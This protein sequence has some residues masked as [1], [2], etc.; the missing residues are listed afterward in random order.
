MILLQTDTVDAL[1][2]RAPSACQLNAGCKILFVSCGERWC[3]ILSQLRHKIFI[4]NFFFVIVYL[5]LIYISIVVHQNWMQ[6]LRYRLYPVSLNS[7]SWATMPPLSRLEQDAHKK[8]LVQQL[9]A[10]RKLEKE[11]Q[12]S[13][14]VKVR[15]AVLYTCY[16]QSEMILPFFCD[17]V[18]FRLRSQSSLFSA[19]INLVL[20]NNISYMND[21][22]YDTDLNTVFLSA[23]LIICVF[24]RPPPR[25]PHCRPISDCLLAT[26]QRIPQP[27]RWMP[28]S[29]KTFCQSCVLQVLLACA[30]CLF[31]LDQLSLFLDVV[32]VVRDA[33]EVE[34]ATPWHDFYEL[35]Y[36]LLSHKRSTSDCKTIGLQKTYRVITEKTTGLELKFN[37]KNTGASL[38]KIWFLNLKLTVISAISAAFMESLFKTRITEVLPHLPLLIP[39]RCD[40]RGAAIEAVA[41]KPCWFSKIKNS[42]V[43]N[44]LAL[45]KAEPA[46]GARRRSWGR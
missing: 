34:F 11:S 30:F 6:I 38:K 31:H 18:C 8:A 7:R 14:T 15:F 43:T 28:A 2:A 35:I 19:Q 25:R 23:T 9:L 10:A 37:C 27:V 33:P 24:K 41:L 12:Q 42:K 3:F 4:H 13:V 26:S 36:G 32:A 21:K 39:P 17:S 46:G 22:Y 16:S 44:A 5:R 45:A 20:V 40:D 29:G 1:S